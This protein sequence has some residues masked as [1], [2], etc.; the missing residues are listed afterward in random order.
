MLPTSYTVEELAKDLASINSR[1]APDYCL[2]TDQLTCM[3]TAQPSNSKSSFNKVV[4]NNSK[5]HLQTSFLLRSTE[6]SYIIC[7]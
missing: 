7:K 3:F 4:T 2:E 1:D 6:F 5:Y